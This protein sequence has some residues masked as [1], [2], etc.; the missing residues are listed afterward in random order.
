M[1]STIDISDLNVSVGQKQET[2]VDG[3]FGSTLDDSLMGG[4]T[5]RFNK[6]EMR[7]KGELSALNTTPS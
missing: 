1:Q 4:G 7:K 2:K 5:T 3:G 6:T